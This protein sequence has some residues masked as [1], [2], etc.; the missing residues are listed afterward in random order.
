MSALKQSNLVDVPGS[1]P[2]VCLLSNGRYSV[3]LTESGGGYSA[4]DGMDVTRWREEPGP[5][6]SGAV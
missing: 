5:A 6:G 2:K 4:R 3:M 1:Y